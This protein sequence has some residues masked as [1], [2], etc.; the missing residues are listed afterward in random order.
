MGREEIQELTVLCIY[1]VIENAVKRIEE[2]KVLCLKISSDKIYA[3]KKIDTAVSEI[4]RLKVIR[5][6]E[7]LMTESWRL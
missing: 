2:K 1:K 4:Y 6:D 3:M 5:A 7:G